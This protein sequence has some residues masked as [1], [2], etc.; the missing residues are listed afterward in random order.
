MLGLEGGGGY[1]LGGTEKNYVVRPKE[2]D[3]TEVGC[4]GEKESRDSA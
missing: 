1:A 2:G 3:G 4:G